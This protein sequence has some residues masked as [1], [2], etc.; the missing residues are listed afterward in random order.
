M[1]F[2][3]SVNKYSG[4]ENVGVYKSELNTGDEEWFIN[5]VLKDKCHHKE[6]HKFLHG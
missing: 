2:Y 4:E 1:F 5:Y 3:K 6:L